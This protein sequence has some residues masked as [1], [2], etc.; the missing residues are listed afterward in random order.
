MKMVAV[1]SMK[2]KACPVSTIESSR[3]LAAGHYQNP[4][5]LSTD[6]RMNYRLATCV[7]LLE[8]QERWDGPGV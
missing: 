1:V 5:Y 3:R 6:D 7:R 8:T 2:R 4:D